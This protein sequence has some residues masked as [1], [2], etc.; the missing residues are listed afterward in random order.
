MESTMYYVA[1]VVLPCRDSAEKIDDGRYNGRS[2]SC[3]LQRPELENAN[4]P[5]YLCTSKVVIN[6]CTHV[7]KYP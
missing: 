4:V 3:R 7:P 6:G 2:C 5:L 1:A